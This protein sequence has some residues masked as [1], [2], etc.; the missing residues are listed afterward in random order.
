MSKLRK[1]L[2]MIMMVIMVLTFAAEPAYAATLKGAGTGDGEIRG[3]EGSVTGEDDFFDADGETAPEISDEI[4][5]ES[6]TGED[7]EITEDLI[8]TDHHDDALKDPEEVHK[9]CVCCADDCTGEGHNKDQ[10]WQAWDSET[11]LPTSQGYYYLTKNVELQRYAEL[12]DGICLCLNG[13]TINTNTKHI[14]CSDS[15]GTITI[16]NCQN[17]GGIVQGE[18]ASLDSSYSTDCMI[19]APKELYLYNVTMT[20]ENYFDALIKYADSAKLSSVYL[21]GCKLTNTNYHYPDTS[22]IRAINLCKGAGDITILNSELTASSTDASN[23]S[24]QV[25]AIDLSEGAGKVTIKNSGIT[26]SADSTKKVYGIYAGNYTGSYEYPIR[27]GFTMKDSTVSV[28]GKDTCFGC[29]IAD[30]HNTEDVN[31]SNSVTIDH[32]TITME[33]NG[34][35]SVYGFQVS[36]N[37]FFKDSTINVTTS[38]DGE[39]TAESDAIGIWNTYWA[40]NAEQVADISLDKTVI[41]VVNNSTAVTY[42]ASGILQYIG[43]L[44]VAN[45]SVI[46][47]TNENNGK[48]YGIWGQSK[49]LRSITGSTISGQT[50][51]VFSSAVQSGSCDT[52]IWDISGSTIHATDSYGV[53]C[54]DYYMGRDI[55]YLSGDCDI[56]GGKGGI[57]IHRASNPGLYA[58]SYVEGTALSP[59]E[60]HG[61]T[62]YYGNTNYSAGTQVVNGGMSQALVGKLNLS[63]PTGWTIDKDGKMVAPTMYKVTLSTKHPTAQYPGSVKATANG[64][65]GYSELQVPAGAEVTLTA[66]ANTFYS[67]DRWE[68]TAGGAVLSSTTEETATF[69]MPAT[70]V[71]ITGHF[72]DTPYYTLTCAPGRYAAETDSETYKVYETFTDG[73]L[74]NPYS[75]LNYTREGYTQTGWSK[76]EDGS[77]CDWNNLHPRI[78][79]S[80]MT[81]NMTI[82]PYWKAD[83]A[84][85]YLAGD[86]GVSPNG[87][88]TVTDPKKPGQTLKIRSA[89]F[90]REGYTQT[91]WRTEPDGSSG[92]KYSFDSNYTTEED[93][94][95]YPEWEADST[96]TYHSNSDYLSDTEYIQSK[97]YDQNVKIKGDVFGNTRQ[98]FLGWST[99]ALGNVEY[100]QGYPY[101]DNED[102]ELWA[103]WM[104]KTY[105]LWVGDTQVDEANKDN[106]FGDGTASFDPATGTLRLSGAAISACTGYDPGDYDVAKY[107]GILV[108]GSLDDVGGTL[109]ADYTIPHLKIEVTG[110]N[111]VNPDYAGA[112]ESS[113]KYGI[114]AYHAAVTVCGEGTLTVG[115]NGDGNKVDCALGAAIYENDQAE[116]RKLPAIRITGSPTLNLYGIS[117]GIAVV[118]DAARYV[119]G[120]AVDGGTVNATASGDAASGILIQVRQAAGVTLNGGALN[121]T[122]TGGTALFDDR[123]S[124]PEAIYVNAQEGNGVQVKGGTLT[125][126]N[127]GTAGYGINADCWHWDGDEDP[128]YGFRYEAGAVTITGKD[129][130]MKAVDTAGSEE[131]YEYLIPVFLNDDATVM[132]GETAETAGEVTDFASAYAGYKY[133]K[134]RGG[135]LP[136]ATYLRLG[137]QEVKDVALEGEV[138]S[139]A[140]ATATLTLTDYDGDSLYTD[141]FGSYGLYAPGDLTINLIG[142][143]SIGTSDSGLPGEGIDCY[144][145]L[146]FTGSGSLDVWG[147]DIGIYAFGLLTVDGPAISSNADRFA[148]SAGTIE[149]NSGYLNAETTMDLDDDEEDYAVYSHYGVTVNGGEIV[150]KAR[151]FGIGIM[152]SGKFILNDGSV[153]AY[154]TGGDDPASICDDR[155]IDI[156]ALLVS[157][158]NDENN[159]DG[160]MNIEVNGGTLYACGYNEGARCDDDYIQRDGS[161]KLIS[162]RTEEDAY[163]NPA[164]WTLGDFIMNGGDL[165]AESEFEVIENGARGCDFIMNGGS[166]EANARS[167]VP[168]T[169]TGGDF[170]IW[171]YNIRINGGVLTLNGANIGLRSA[172][173]GEI[174]MNGGSLLIDLSEPQSGKTNYATYGMLEA[175]MPFFRYRTAKDAPYTLKNGSENINCP[176]LKNTY[177]EIAAISTVTYK[178]G[179]YGTGDDVTEAKIE[180]M[181]LTL[182]DALFTRDGHVQTGWSKTDGGARDYDL[183]G[184][185]TNDVSVTLYPEWCVAVT[186]TYAPGTGCTGETYEDPVA[187]G[188]STV[189]RGA[190]YTKDG[191][192]QTGWTTVEDGNKEYDLEGTATF[193]TAKTLYPAWS[194]E[195]T[196]TYE[197]GRAG[198]GDTVEEPAT[199]GSDYTLRGALFTRSGYKQ[200]GW[201]LTDGGS[202]KYELSQNVAFTGDTTLYPAWGKKCRLNYLAGNA[203]TAA[204]TVNPLYEDAGKY[205]LDIAEG[206][207]VTLPGA[208]FEHIPEADEDQWVQVG[209]SKRIN[210]TGENY[211]GFGANVKFNSS[212][213]LYP[214]WMIDGYRLEIEGYEDTVTVSGTSDRIYV[215]NYTGKAI[216][217]VIRVYD[218]SNLLTEKKDYKLTVKNNKGVNMKTAELAE[219]GKLVTDQDSGLTAKQLKKIP[220]FEIAGKNNY[221]SKQRIYFAIAPAPIDDGSFTAADDLMIEFANKNGRAVA[222]KPVPAVTGTLGGKTKKLKNK[223]EYTVTY[224]AAV[225][226]IYG[227]YQK[228]E[229][230]L[231][232]YTGEPLPYLS[233]RGNYVIR[234]D[235]KGSFTGTLT[236]KVK[237]TTKKSITKAKV[238]Y[239]KSLPYSNGDPVF[240]TKVTVKYG[241]TALKEN[242]DYKITYEPGTNRE[243]GTAIM[244]VDGIGNYEGRLTVK[245]SVTGTAISKVKLEKFADSFEYDG[246][247]KEQPEAKLYVKRGNAK[248][249]LEYGTDYT[250]R[251]ENNIN[252]GTATAIYTG[253]GAYS[254]TLK[255]KYKVQPFDFAKNK[256]GR[257]DVTLADTV[258]FSKGGAVPNVAV[259]FTKADGTEVTLSTDSYGLSLSNNKAVNDATGRKKPTAT[260]TGKKNFKG[261]YNAGA[262]V[263]TAK[264]FDDVTL[265]AY[266]KAY[267]N[268]KDNY[269]TTISAVDTDGKALKAGTDYDKNVIYKY[270]EATTVTNK[271]KQY[272]RAAGDAVTKGDIAP[273]G[274]VMIAIVKAK[275]NY[276]GEEEREFVI[277]P[278]S[279]AKAQAEFDRKFYYDRGNPVTPGKDD[280]RLKVKKGRNWEY[281]DPSEYEIVP[282]SYAG[283]TKCGTASFKVVG[284]GSSAGLITVKFKILPKVLELLFG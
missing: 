47:V 165:Y 127:S 266:D 151:N 30:D 275:G 191:H 238:S 144:G 110:T 26:A 212:A 27:D 68:V 9:H 192:I 117:Y 100:R 256:D 203:P 92:T 88:T 11:A 160:V 42:T 196:I 55:V 149:M 33:Q 140:P 209:W 210:D 29:I 45:G 63:Y 41:N 255:K 105:A 64:K 130:A 146:T 193:S 141:D 44:T 10:V 205:S 177:L 93:L 164:I 159:G 148:I 175:G 270:R 89:L 190:T 59:G 202:K 35:S 172:D 222:N 126:T 240:Q 65:E 38:G 220:Y 271:G 280:F 43:D 242:T 40:S 6:L 69:T 213:T 158:G 147:S 91:A 233:A 166:V 80:E 3:E 258:V 219:L 86:Y 114:A 247:A 37:C 75:Q 78:K 253:K 145:D 139:Y 223:T 224:Y 162:A 53:Y 137:D 282:G 225:T 121:A 13:H 87:V 4:S 14:S 235:G 62:V 67:F 199:P 16:C 12:P 128:I 278:Q 8:I 120:L 161:V 152:D 264:S 276:T 15:N 83:T 206:E 54:G 217:P 195:I 22:A 154:A 259:K 136:P 248:V 134:I 124:Y 218:G 112:P 2:S 236:S 273:E 216:K 227:D 51:G 198:S 97:P 103:V 181:P 234:I 135:V 58:S 244:Y 7:A 245:F 118:A 108:L 28:T 84:V 95:L 102:L 23:G 261:K 189:L 52:A 116:T 207:E 39:S 123:L 131:Y 262:F 232:K 230:G 20:S 156:I 187:S 265:I 168:N 32:S 194:D 250:V 183:K 109:E 129:G 104:D 150:A 17:T 260:V 201:A 171:Y 243:I 254:G 229:D 113:E 122:T 133:A 155:Y 90:M 257:L 153:S 1:A 197:K 241:K 125:L 60:G 186:L 176:N 184:T 215:F 77:T 56:T 24:F 115:A 214:V 180:G 49:S 284:A 106:I 182:A 18:I 200:T 61:V 81:G 269:T 246:T 72:K 5:E 94:T 237:I 107:C 73:E 239:K 99:S 96:I 111:T 169:A 252:A 76:S 21:D 57:Y 170:T 142:N 272:D 188:A 163:L 204:G 274:T 85:T 143:S 178:P 71:K 251:Y 226:D 173:G 157:D 167:E 138:W 249:Y 48:G 277:R 211:Y 46:T 221:G 281:I 174:S 34:P 231:Y 19:S 228:D 79:Y 132:A 50:Y 208:M 82:Y 279:I 70:A 25:R 179:E 74:V 283:N 267:A 31:E 119:D 185:Y 101:S 66:K 268:K 98:T 36:G 263:I